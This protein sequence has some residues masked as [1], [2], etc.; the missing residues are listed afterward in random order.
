[1]TN[2]FSVS[3]IIPF[4]NSK[5]DIAKCIETIKSQDMEEKVEIIFID[6]CS[7]DN[8]AQIIKDFQLPNCNLL[9]LNRNQGPSAARNKGLAKA[10]GDYV[11]FLDVDDSL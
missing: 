4:Y 6:D 11:F 5:K 8:S 10:S 3:L 9:T 7:Q 1:M 2:N